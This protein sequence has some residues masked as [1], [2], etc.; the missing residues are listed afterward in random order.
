MQTDQMKAEIALDDK[1]YKKVYKLFI[2]E[3]DA[4]RE[5]MGGSR[6]QRPDM[7]G[8]P[9]GHGGPGGGG[10][11]GGGGPGMGGG[12]PGGG[13]GGPGGGFGGPEMSGGGE[14]NPGRGDDMESRYEQLES[15]Y[16]KND[17]QLQKILT[18]EQYSQWRQAHPV[19]RP[20][21]PE[22]SF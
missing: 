12:M 2:K 22:M 1:Q 6:P 13:M 15:V 17:K 14:F 3:I 21:M 9:G 5:F 16:A 4:E 7:Q 11:P 8:G 18:P 20:P 10:F 19:K